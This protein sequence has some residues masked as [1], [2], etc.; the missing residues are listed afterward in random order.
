MEKI[1]VHD[2]YFKPYIKEQELMKYIDKVA[3]KV[4]ADYKDNKDIPIFLC[5]LNGAM[6]FTAEM[7]KRLNFQ[8]ELVSIKMSSYE[9]TTS[10]GTVLIPMGLTGDVSG[11]DVI[12]FEDIVDTG[13]TIL[14]LK[15]L[16]LTK[17]A[18][19]VRICAMLMKPE[20]FKQN[21]KIDYVGKEIPNDFIV[22]FGLDYNELGRNLRDIYVID[23]D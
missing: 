3:A 1:K 16:L 22:G 11:R 10:T 9:G 20:S 2:K 7:M 18:R 14:A 6:M 12:I 23:N 13:V 21:V 15:E 8:A 4:N 17:G 5:V 19:S